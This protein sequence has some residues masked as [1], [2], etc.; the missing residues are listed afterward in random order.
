MKTPNFK[1]KIFIILMLFDRER[2]GINYQS[3]ILDSDENLKN[4]IA[5]WRN[6]RK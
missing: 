6:L 1:L 2:L 4:F 3:D 5:N